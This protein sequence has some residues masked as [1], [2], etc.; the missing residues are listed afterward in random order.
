MFFVKMFGENVFCD[1]D[2]KKINA[3]ATIYVNVNVGLLNNLCTGCIKSVYIFLFSGFELSFEIWGTNLD[4][5]GLRRSIIKNSHGNC[6]E[7][8][9]DVQLLR[10]KTTQQPKKAS[11]RCFICKKLFF[12]H[13]IY[14]L[15]NNFFVSI[16]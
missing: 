8:R 1:F 11:E 7:N 16:F 5:Y 15:A 4:L 6:L 12:D 10:Q 3:S 13:E 14:T 2:F 9:Q